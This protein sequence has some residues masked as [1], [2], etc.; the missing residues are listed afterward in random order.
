MH[1][2]RFLVRDETGRGFS[3]E[4]ELED[5]EKHDLEYSNDPDD[6][7]EQ[8]LGEQLN[9]LNTC[10]GDEYFHEDDRFTIIRIS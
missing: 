7:F 9:A 6:E 10:P 2:R 4:F 1:D 8:T 5:F 3:Q